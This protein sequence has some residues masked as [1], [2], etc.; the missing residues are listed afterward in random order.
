MEYSTFL[1]RPLCTPLIYPQLLGCIVVI[2]IRQ[3]YREKDSNVGQFDPPVFYTVTNVHLQL[4]VPIG[5]S[6]QWLERQVGKF[7]QKLPFVSF[8]CPGTVNV[9]SITSLAEPLKI[10]PF[11]LLMPRRM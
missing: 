6:S 9:P 1:D 2:T 11:F 3:S 5:T 4:N 7:E 8:I 10:M